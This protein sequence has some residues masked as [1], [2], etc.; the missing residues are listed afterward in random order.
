MKDDA[1]NPLPEFL[2][3]TPGSLRLPRASRWKRLPKPTPPEGARWDNAERYELF[4]MPGPGISW[5]DNA[6]K[7]QGLAA[8]LRRVWV[9]REGVRK[10]RYWLSDGEREVHIDEP[11]WRLMERRARKIIPTA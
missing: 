2:K 6:G 3:A 11:T 8:G 10:V 9:A 5:T 4:V 7:S 1:T